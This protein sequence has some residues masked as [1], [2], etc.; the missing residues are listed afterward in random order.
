M[1]RKIKKEINAYG[2]KVLLSPHKAIRSLKRDF[3]PDSHGNRFWW[4][5]WLLMDYFERTGLEQG[6]RVLEIGCGWGLASI[7][8]AKA[9]KA[10]VTGADIDRNVLPYAMLHAEINSVDVN[11]IRKGFESFT[12]KD[13][14]GFDV[15]L[16]ADICFWENMTRPLKNL[17]KRAQKAGVKEMFISDPVRSPFEE[18]SKY[19]TD[20]GEGEVLD[21][22]SGEPREILG[23]ILRISN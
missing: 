12:K 7:Y 18:L 23:Q 14:E 3:K 8:C 15:I 19:F 4:S 17:I 9:H 11:F 5:S 6:S 2:I 10:M 21:W 13:L 20:R 16:G 22:T 1:R